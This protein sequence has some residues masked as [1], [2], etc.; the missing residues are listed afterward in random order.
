MPNFISPPN[1]PALGPINKPFSTK[2]RNSYLKLI[3]ALCKHGKIDSLGRQAVSDLRMCTKAI[4]L[5]PSNDTLRKILN[6]LKDI[7]E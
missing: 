4:E 3:V 7:V 1:Y 5:P 2:E 6:E